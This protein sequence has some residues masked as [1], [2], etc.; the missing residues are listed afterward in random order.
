VLDERGS[1]DAVRADMPGLVVV[2][3]DG[4]G[5]A[6]VVDDA[7]LL[8]RSTAVAPVVV[9]LPWEQLQEPGAVLGDL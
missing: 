7:L 6:G 5:A 4:C 1:A 8:V 3:C 2:A 9:V